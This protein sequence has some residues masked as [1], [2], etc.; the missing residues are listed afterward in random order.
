MAC[1]HLWQ[2]PET[3]FSIKHC[4]ERQLK[5]IIHLFETFSVQALTLP[6]SERVKRSLSST[7]SS[8]ERNGLSSAELKK[9]P[10]TARDQILYFEKQK[11]LGNNAGNKTNI[12][13]QAPAYQLRGIYGHYL[14]TH[15]HHQFSI[16][17]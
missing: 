12:S 10:Q 1:S 15:A 17:N 4:T 7:N 9:M 2:S 8:F 6:H 3:K 5:K 14:F 11:N 13:A 16:K